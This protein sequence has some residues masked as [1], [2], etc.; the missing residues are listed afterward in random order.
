MTGKLQISD[1]S[2]YRVDSWN[3]EPLFSLISRSLL[4]QTSC[5]Y[6]VLVDEGLDQTLIITGHL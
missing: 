5:R 6:I 1:P 4:I 2:G 3:R